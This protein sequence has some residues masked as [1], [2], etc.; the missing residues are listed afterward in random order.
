ME[1]ITLILRYLEQK[2]D[3]IEAMPW[4]PL[5]FSCTGSSIRAGRWFEG[6]VIHILLSTIIVNVA[7]TAWS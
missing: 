7:A 3:R 4:P 1:K 2:R 6:S 5:L